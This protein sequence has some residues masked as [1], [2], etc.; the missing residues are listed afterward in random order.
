MVYQQ[1]AA[2]CSESVEG[3]RMVSISAALYGGRQRGNRAAIWRSAA[4][5]APA[6]LESNGGEAINHVT[7]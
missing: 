2:S 5:A 6:A 4:A 1:A 3:Q 7:A